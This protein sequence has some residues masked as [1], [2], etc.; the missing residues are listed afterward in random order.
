MDA[1]NVATAVIGG[2]TEFVTTE[3]PG[4]PVYRVRAVVVRHLLVESS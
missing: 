2:A 4:K 3:K 1:L